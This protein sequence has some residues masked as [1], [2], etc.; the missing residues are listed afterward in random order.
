MW[1]H[2]EHRKE[3]NGVFLFLIKLASDLNRL[4]HS[5]WHYRGD[6]QSC[7]A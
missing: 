3:K 5:L 6:V 1:E 4:T 7:L 2:I